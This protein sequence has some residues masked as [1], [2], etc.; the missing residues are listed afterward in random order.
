MKEAPTKKKP[1]TMPRVVAAKPA[2]GPDPG[3]KQQIQQYETA[4]RLMH[5]GKYEK[6]KAALE[7]LIASDAGDLIDRARVHCNACERQ[8]AKSE[9][10]FS[11]PEERFDY[12]VSLLNGG[13]YEDARE[14]F[15]AIVMV[16]PTA[17]YAHYGLALLYCMTGRP[18]DCFAALAR[19]I[20]LNP[21]NRIQ[22]RLDADFQELVDDPRF[23]ELLYPEIA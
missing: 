10:K 7:A 8:I 17:D 1:A 14:H 2:P 3:R 12:A 23:T 6:A 11:T 22:A 16:V 5:E 19:A 18:E 4:V 20:E 15:D 9:V 13:F 21:R